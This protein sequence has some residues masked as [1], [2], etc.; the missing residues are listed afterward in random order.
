M[1][2]GKGNIKMQ[3]PKMWKFIVIPFAIGIVLLAGFGGGAYY[4]MNGSKTSK[5]NQA[6]NL[7]TAGNYQEAAQAFEK[8]GDYRDSKMRFAETSA[9]MHFENGKYAFS[10]GDY[11]KAKEEFIAA[12]DYENAKLLAEESERAA[13]YAK[14]ESLGASGD[15][16]KAIEEYT[17]SGYKDYKDKVADLYSSKS[18]KAI[19]DGNYDQAIE[20][21]KNASD[22]KGTEEPVLACYY[23]MGEDSRAKNDLENAGSYFT[24][25]KEY[26]D[27][28]D[29]S[30][31]VY[32]TMGTEALDKKDYENAA[33]YFKLAADYKDVATIAKEAFY[34]TATKRYNA[35]DY[36][37]ASEY[38]KL[39]GSYKDA[40][41]FYL[42]STYANGLAQLKAKNYAEAAELFENCG[43][44][45]YSKDMVNV[46]IAEAAM[47]KENISE[48]MAAYKKVSAKAKISGFDI[49]GRKAFASR[50][51]AIDKVC[52][53]YS[54]Y[55][56]H[57][58]ATK[59]LSDRTKYALYRYIMPGQGI[60]IK[61]SVNSD[62]T[63]NITGAVAWGRITKYADTPENVGL[64]VVVSNFQFSHVKKFP[65]SFKLSGGAKISYK[66]GKFQLKF[67][68]KSGKIKYTSN[69]SYS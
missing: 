51:Y 29:K 10:T 40:N 21:A 25:A 45:K 8:L 4:L 13:H 19:A 30:K 66:N 63:F 1:L 20:F 14:G 3:Q 64:K 57:I 15:F 26:K 32:Y 37:A 11:E 60:S 38:Y 50:W 12:G 9:K 39:A 16:D 53:D 65:T 7:Y 31:A 24:S 59:R 6:V 62:G 23:K 46:C 49:Q 41:S 48:A 28:P 5:Y 44:Y 67:N 27:A 17:K 33:G 35:K 18:D 69:V 54:V 22:N 42:A 55:S 47:A 43:S 36:A 52:H 68:K 56:N 61:Y 34:I 58:I 2:E